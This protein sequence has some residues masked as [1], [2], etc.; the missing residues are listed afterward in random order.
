MA[1]PAVVSNVSVLPASEKQ[2]QQQ[3]AAQKG[4]AA[5][6]N[7]IPQRSAALWPMPPAACWPFMVPW[8]MPMFG[9]C[10]SRPVNCPEQVAR[11]SDLSFPQHRTHRAGKGGGAL[12]MPPMMQQQPLLPGKAQLRKG[13]SIPAPTN[14]QQKPTPA[15]AASLAPQQPAA[16]KGALP[17]TTTTTDKPAATPAGAAPAEET[18][19]LP[20]ELEVFEKVAAME[21]EQQQQKQQVRVFVCACPGDRSHYKVTLRPLT[22]CSIAGSPNMLA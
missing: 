20:E 15:A 8:G 11:R 9:R 2:Q 21:R 13:S 1:A 14:Q 5:P 19:I 7:V 4:S 17:T 18:E 10:C 22:G 3:T 12:Q 6:S 16:A